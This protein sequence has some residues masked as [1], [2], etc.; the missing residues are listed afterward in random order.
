MGKK[1]KKRKE[2]KL[3]KLWRWHVAKEESGGKFPHME[4]S[5]DKVE[6]EENPEKKG[7]E[8]K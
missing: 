8:N 7:K 6:K 5:V 4:N 3:R 1:N 2:K